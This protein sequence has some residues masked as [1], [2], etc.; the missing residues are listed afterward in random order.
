MSRKGGEQKGEEAGTTTLFTFTSLVHPPLFVLGRPP[1][2]RQQATTKNKQHKNSAT[3]EAANGENS[4]SAAE[5]H[6][7]DQVLDVTSLDSGSVKTN[8]TKIISPAAGGA[9]KT[10]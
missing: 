9:P 2:P 4:S 7:P 8:D 10:L 6:R 1:G 3:M 5:D